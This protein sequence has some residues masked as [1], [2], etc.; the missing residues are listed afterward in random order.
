MIRVRAVQ[1]CFVLG[2]LRK[3]GDIFMV[4]DDQVLRT[5]KMP[6]VMELVDEELKPK[7]GRF[8]KQK[9]AQPDDAED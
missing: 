2:G 5:K 7:R 3:V 6:P 9:T 1:K 4:P 8:K